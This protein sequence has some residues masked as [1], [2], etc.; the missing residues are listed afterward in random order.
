MSYRARATF[1]V[2]TPS[3]CSSFLFFEESLQSAVVIE[4]AANSWSGIFLASLRSLYD[5]GASRSSVYRRH[6]W[7]DIYRSNVFLFSPSERTLKFL[8]LSVKLKHKKAKKKKEKK[9]ECSLLLVISFTF[10]LN[11][12]DEKYPTQCKPKFCLTKRFRLGNER[13]LFVLSICD[14]ARGASSKP[15][16]LPI[17]Y[18]DRLPA[19]LGVNVLRLPGYECPPFTP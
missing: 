10:F 11:R 3:S 18:R 6:L 13:I 2:R 9:Q 16:Q 4:S 1:R 14:D 12:T 19:E 15:H 8:S 7:N 17:N 5:W